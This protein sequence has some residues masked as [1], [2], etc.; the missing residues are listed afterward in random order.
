MD[1]RNL[2][3]ETPSSAEKKIISLLSQDRFKIE[4][5]NYCCIVN[6]LSKAVRLFLEMNDVVLNWKI[7]HVANDKVDMLLIGPTLE[8]HKRN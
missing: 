1:L 6:N 5:G 3:K 4:R 8:E 2:P 7:M